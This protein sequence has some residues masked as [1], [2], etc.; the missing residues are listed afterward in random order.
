MKKC[1]A[2]PKNLYAHFVLGLHYEH[3]GEQEQALAQF[4]L[5][6]EA[7]PQD[8]Y[9]AY[10]YAEALSGLDRRDEAGRMFERV[11]ALD[12]SF[13]SAVY[14]LA[15]YYQ[16]TDRQEKA[17]ELFHR[18]SKLGTVDL[19]GNPR[20]V[21]FVY[22]TAGK[23]HMSLGLEQ[24][25]LAPA[26]GRRDAR[27]LFS[28]QVRELDV[29]LKP[30]KWAGGSVNVPGIAVGDLN[31]DDNLDLVLTSVGEKGGSQVFFGNG[32]GS[33]TAGPRLADE[34]VSPCLGDVDN[35]GTL[36]LWLGR[37]GEDIL[38]LN[39]GK[40]N[41]TKAPPVSSATDKRMTVCARLL[42]IDNDGD[43]DLI[44]L[45]SA[46]GSVPARGDGKPGPSRVWRNNRDGGF[47]DIAE[48]LG[49]AFEQTA[50]ALLLYADFN[51]G[52]RLDLI[53]FPAGKPPVLW[54]NDLAGG[55]HLLD[56]AATGLKVNR[57]VSA[58]CGDPNKDGRPDV[59]IFTGD[60]V[61]LF[62][63]R[64]QFHFEEDQEFARRFS[65]LGGTSG[66]FVDIDD[67]G[68]LDLVIADAH[69][70]D[71]TR[72][73][74]LLINDW[75]R[76]RFLDA[77]EVDP[78]NLLSAIKF[79]GDASCVAADFF[80]HGRCDI[81]LA[82][83]GGK[84]MLV[85]NVTRGGHCVEID[86]VGTKEQDKKTRSDHSAVGAR[87]EV[88]S[89]MISQQYLV[90]ACSGAVSMP[91]LRVHAGIGDNTKVDW[92]RVFW[93]DCVF[94]GE[95]ELAGDRLFQISETQRKLVSCPHL[96]AWNGSRFELVCD[97]G[98]M[99]GLGYLTGPGKYNTPDPIEY[100]RIPQLV[101]RGDEYVLQVLE[102]L[103]EVTYLDEVKLI[104]VD[105]PAGTE[106]YPNEMMA[107]NTPRPPFELLCIKNAIEP[108]RA[109][110]HRGVDVTEAIRHLDR[111]YAGVTELDRR[112]T[113]F[114]KEHF[115]ELDFGDRL[116]KTSK[117]ARLI[118]F[119][120]GSVEYDYSTTSFA[121]AQAGIRLK[122]PSISRRARRPLG[123]T[124]PRS[125]LPGRHPAHDDPRSHR[126]GPPRRS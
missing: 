18:F 2:E 8:P 1:C 77:A 95:T 35:N 108:V 42:D 37:A 89:G 43:L 70:R 14:R 26:S 19:S 103:E 57:A 83:S 53:A 56:A 113:G 41:L 3:N 123:G 7:D 119:L 75:P 20:K 48:S 39:D 94:Q 63:N 61:R 76:Q 109:V 28:P 24:L 74:V 101:P 107:V 124:V 16:R 6:Y 72:G 122:A 36:D 55:Y 98:G 116:A 15:Q 81:L 73:P 85:E 96:F 93:P 110:D 10:K 90:G 5:V 71:G 125:G 92:L 105:H 64:G 9:A 34:A 22:G 68:D 97:F 44:S 50:M 11:V 45:R 66:Q 62:L 102:P 27:I 17:V 111:Q 46:A 23:Y 87:V 21:Q 86:L 12:P 69:R 120:Q 121:A 104:A 84:P 49:L 80:G 126:Q 67:D 25:P 13:A 51:N 58:I 114:A 65:K 115:V 112:F 78:G 99:G 117:D 60:E 82:P 118:L 29:T 91:P 52:R 30:W 59:L 38:Y 4:R 79:K 88:K 33:F 100:V 31:G 54:V 32:K 47:V 40:G 106:V